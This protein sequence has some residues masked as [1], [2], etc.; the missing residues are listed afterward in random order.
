MKSLK[1]TRK[2]IKVLEAHGC[3]TENTKKGVNIF[4]PSTHLN[5]QLDKAPFY[6]MHISDRS[7][8]KP[9]LDFVLNHWDTYLVAA[10]AREVSK[11]GYPSF[12]AKVAKRSGQ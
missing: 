4:P 11:L 10:F 6:S 2:L 9:F 8:L 5:R 12:A 7:G 3:R 1:E